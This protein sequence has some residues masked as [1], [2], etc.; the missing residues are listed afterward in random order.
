MPYASILIPLYLLNISVSLNLNIKQNS[1]RHFLLQKQGQ[2][3]L[4]FQV[5]LTILLKSSYRIRELKFFIYYLI[6][7]PLSSYSNSLS[8][9]LIQSSNVSFES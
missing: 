4:S 5:Q 2:H 7:C 3:V 6:R 8:R 1:P 9:N